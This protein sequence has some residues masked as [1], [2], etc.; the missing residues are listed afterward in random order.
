MNDYILI[1]RQISL[2]FINGHQ[3]KF[4]K[5]LFILIQTIKLILINQLIIFSKDFLLINF[6]K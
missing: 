5:L 2:N 1:D 3:F 4:N 6:F